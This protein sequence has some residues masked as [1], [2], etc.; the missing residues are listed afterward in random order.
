MARSGAGPDLSETRFGKEYQRLLKTLPGF[1]T[2]YVGQNP[3]DAAPVDAEDRT[4]GW[5]PPD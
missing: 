1:C 2:D 4:F 3:V 5:T